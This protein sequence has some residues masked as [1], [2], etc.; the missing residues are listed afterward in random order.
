MSETQQ[1]IKKRRR[2]DPEVA[3][4]K[5]IAASVDQMNAD[6]RRALIFWLADRYLGIKLWNER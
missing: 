1:T 6:S 3:A 4:L 2:P 5:K